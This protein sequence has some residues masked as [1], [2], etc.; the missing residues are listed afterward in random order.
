MKNKMIHMIKKYNIYEIISIFKNI[1]AIINH[2]CIKLHQIE[3]LR[4]RRLFY[5]NINY[6]ISGLS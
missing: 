1:E 5:Y 3:V 6:S 4:N 2:T